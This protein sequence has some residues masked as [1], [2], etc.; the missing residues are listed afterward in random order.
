[1]PSSLRTSDAESRG[2]VRL[3]DRYSHLS[4]L[5]VKPDLGAYLRGIWA[6]REFLITVP[7]NELRAQNQNTVLGNLWHL[8]NPL[9]LAGVYYLVF[10]VILNARGRVE[11]Y[12]AF[13][14]TGLFTFFFTQ[15]A[16][17]AGTRTIIANIKLIRSIS[18]PRAIL[19]ISA[20][21]GEGI[22]QVPALTAMVALVLITGVSPSPAWL[23]V[24]PIMVVQA[25]FNL[26]WAFL[27]SRLTFHFRDVQQFLPYVMR[28][29]LYFS[30]VFFA[31]DFVPAGTPRRIFEMNPMYQFIHLN[32]LALL[33]GT[34]DLALLG[35]VSMWAVAAL[36]F[37]FF[38][39]RAH[40]TEYGRG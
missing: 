37:G 40:E 21:I 20:V 11:N 38:F 10:G 28:I 32:R 35:S 7:I 31:A 14:I 34:I 5:G 1:M 16:I 25:F 24:I 15:K 27:S 29:W 39:F 12:P 8:L 3:T 26:G 36:L 6:R 17:M 19:P 22:A 18:F 4:Q 13:L 23:L 33:D 2:V 9:F 30:G